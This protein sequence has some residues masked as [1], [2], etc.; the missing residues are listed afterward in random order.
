MKDLNIPNAL[1]LVAMLIIVSHK[2]LVRSKGF[3]AS[4]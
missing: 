4:F 1:A 3:L 2:G